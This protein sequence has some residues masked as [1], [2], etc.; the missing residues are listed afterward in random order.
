MKVGE[1]ETLKL[2]RRGDNLDGTF[3]RIHN[4]ISRRADTKFDTVVPA[5]TNNLNKP[6]CSPRSLT[7]K[8]KEHVSDIKSFSNIPRML[9]CKIPPRND[10]YRVKI[11]INH[12]STC[13]LT[14]TKR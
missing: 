3:S 4:F 2:T 13:W 11:K 1:T 12:L 9:L 6:S 8:L 14:N 10:K 5:G 7:D